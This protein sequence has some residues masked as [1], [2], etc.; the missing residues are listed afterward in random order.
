MTLLPPTTP[1]HTTSYAQHITSYLFSPPNTLL[2]ILSIHSHILSIPFHTP[3]QHP[4]T[5]PL[6]THPHTTHPHDKQAESVRRLWDSLRAEAWL[7]YAA[8]QVD[9][10][11]THPVDTLHTIS[12]PYTLYQHSHP[13]N[14]HLNTLSSPSNKYSLST[15]L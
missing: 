1:H 7:V 11:I 3:Y 2:H 15:T 8:G 10:F 5:H 12:H 13:I 14:T 4:P 6:T 9:I